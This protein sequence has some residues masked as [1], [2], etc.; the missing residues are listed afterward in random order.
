[1]K[2][3]VAGCKVMHNR[4]IPSSMQYRLLVTADFPEK[5][6]TPMLGRGQKYQSNQSTEMSVK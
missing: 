3:S 5:N 2:F 6:T 4:K 1:M